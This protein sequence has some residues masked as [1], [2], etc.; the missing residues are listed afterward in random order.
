MRN[1]IQLLSR[2]LD[3]HHFNADLDPA[4]HINAALHVSIL[5]LESWFNAELDPAFY[6]EFRIRITLMQILFRI[7]LF[8]FMRIRIPLFTVMR[9]RIQL[10]KT[11]L[12]HA[13][14]DTKP[15]FS[16]SCTRSRLCH[17]KNKLNLYPSLVSDLN[18]KRN[19]LSSD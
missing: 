16:G 17:P 8:T 1:Q 3:P 6:P 7:Q 13:N 12:I 18:L 15:Y 4:F 2:V 19:H 9:I 5:S 10:P 11:M 14:P